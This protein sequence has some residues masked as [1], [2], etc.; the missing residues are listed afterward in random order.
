[1]NDG[2]TCLKRHVFRSKCHYDSFYIKFVRC[3]LQKFKKDTFSNRIRKIVKIK[4][5]KISQGINRYYYMKD[6][7]NRLSSPSFRILL[8]LL[9][10]HTLKVIKKTKSLAIELDCKNFPERIIIIFINHINYSSFIIQTI[11]CT[12]NEIINSTSLVSF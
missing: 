9:F 4:F 8:K 11:L 3:T 1:M 2:I 7:R 6:S 12:N 5:D 10:L